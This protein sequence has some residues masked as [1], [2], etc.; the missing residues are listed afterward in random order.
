M[1]IT[2]TYEMFSINVQI[3]LMEAIFAAKLLLNLPTSALTGKG[4]SLSRD[5][6]PKHLY[7]SSFLSDVGFF[8]SLTSLLFLEDKKQKV[9]YIFLN[10]GPYFQSDYF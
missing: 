7:N 5:A 10:L 9:C 8:S 3:W 1:F 4:S 2:I 6:I